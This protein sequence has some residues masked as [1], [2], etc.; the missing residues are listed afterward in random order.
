MSPPRLRLECPEDLDQVGVI[1]AMVATI[2]APDDDRIGREIAA[3]VADQARDD[4][5]PRA[6]VDPG[7]SVPTTDTTSLGID[8]TEIPE[9]VPSGGPRRFR[10]RWHLINALEIVP[11]DTGRWIM[12]VGLNC[13]D[14]NDYPDDHPAGSPCP[15]CGGRK[16]SESMLCTRCDRTGAD[17]AMRLPGLAVGTSLRGDCPPEYL[18]RPRYSAPSRGGMSYRRRGAAG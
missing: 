16:F 17:A 14:A 9:A 6:V 7:S 8:P 12:L 3:L 2:L 5:S 10:Q 13:W 15:I 4:A 1:E 11:A 18:I